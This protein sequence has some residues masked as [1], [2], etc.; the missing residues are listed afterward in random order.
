MSV[1]DLVARFGFDFEKLGAAILRGEHL[2]RAAL[3]QN[4]CVRDADVFARGLPEDSRRRFEQSVLALARSSKDPRIR[5]PAWDLCGRLRIVSS[6]PCLR[7][8]L[9][10]ASAERDYPTRGIVLLALAEMGDADRIPRA[11]EE[12]R[13]DGPNSLEGFLILLRHA[14]GEFRRALRGVP[15]VA[16]GGILSALRFFKGLREGAGRPGGDVRA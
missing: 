14:R 5:R 11:L 2:G 9:A 6:L 13:R 4:E 3:N 10:R 8:E 16:R 7:Q 15:P 1:D 12:I